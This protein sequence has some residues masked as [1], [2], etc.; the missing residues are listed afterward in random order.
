VIREDIPGADTQP[1][2]VAIYLAPFHRAEISL[3]SQLL[4][5]LYTSANRMAAFRTVDWDK[6][7][8]WLHRHTHAELAPE[9][10]A[11]VKLALT[12]NLAVLTG[13]PGC[14]KSSR[15]ARSSPSLRR[16]APRLC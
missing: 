3:A 13:G 2:T 14:G 11:A 12:E 8:A 10:H 1:V 16:N 7:L 6:A 4:T 9:Q 5:L 15:C